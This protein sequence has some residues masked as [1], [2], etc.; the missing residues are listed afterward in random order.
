MAARTPLVAGNWKM[1][2]SAVMAD[3]LLAAIAADRP[4][5]VDVAVFPPMPY[6]AP[7]HAAHATSGIALGGQDV[8]EH[9]DEGAFTGEV[10]AAMLHDVGAGMVLVGHSERRQLHAESNECVAAK[11]AAAA[12]AGLAPVLCL[13]ESLED[14]E[15]GR[16]EAVVGEQLAAVLRQAGVDGFAGAVVAYEP[17]WAIGTGKTATPGQVDEVHAFLRS[18]LAAQDAKLARL[19]RIVYG[20]SVKP[21][22]ATD[23]FACEHVD[24]G[25]IGGASLRAN[26]FLSICRA[27]C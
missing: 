15:A 4:D 24:G 8:S 19:T 9:A 17:I 14:R 7:L 3:D 13:G 11:F 27:A 20:G 1:H 25:L 12:A 10:S 21:D 22:N 5:G 18:Q 26:D 16:T 2:G 6:I 23:L